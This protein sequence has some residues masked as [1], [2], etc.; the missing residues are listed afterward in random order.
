MAVS[1]PTSPEHESAPGAPS[2][3]APAGC[4]D[5]ASRFSGDKS[6]SSLSDEKPAGLP[7]IRPSEVLQRGTSE[8]RADTGCGEAVGGVPDRPRSRSDSASTVVPGD[9][10]EQHEQRAR[11]DV[12]MDVRFTV[13][14][15]AAI[16]DRARSL[17]VRPSAWGRAVM[18]DALDPRLGRVEKLSRLPAAP[19]PELARAVEQL[20]RVGVNL[21]QVKRAG[22]AVD[23]DLLLKV[24]G[25]VDEVRASLGDRTAI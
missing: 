6:A 19:Q 14:E 13:R 2:P 9:G 4:E 7:R 25:V 11:R 17:G 10:M 22:S 15:R 20:R 1:M 24:L 8:A 18:L 21:N 5:E 12:S 3:A 23:D 16:R